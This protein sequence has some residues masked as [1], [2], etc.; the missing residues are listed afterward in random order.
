VTR[1]PTARRSR[2]GHEQDAWPWV[3]AIAVML[4]SRNC[5]DVDGWAQRSKS[6]EN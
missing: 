6:A 3:V 1:G 2:G 5:D 4:V